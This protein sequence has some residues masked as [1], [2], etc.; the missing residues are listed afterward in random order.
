MKALLFILLL[1]SAFARD[2]SD[3]CGL[4]WQV[5]KK[6]TLSATTTRGTTN[7]VVPPTF[8]MT[9]GT[10]GCA[11]HGFVKKNKQLIHFVEVNFEALQSDMV[12]G[13]G[14]TLSALASLCNTNVNNFVGKYNN[15]K[16]GSPSALLA[17]V[18]NT[19]SC[20]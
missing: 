19:V 13:R 3:G 16:A 9:T 6:K 8:G 20:I 10:I 17:K 12:N 15:L 14:E 4:G 11:K 7:S 2:K 18:R 5:T 1:T